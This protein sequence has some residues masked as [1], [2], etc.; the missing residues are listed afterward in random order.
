MKS[1]VFSFLNKLLQPWNLE[2]AVHRTTS[3]FSP[4]LLAVFQSQLREVQKQCPEFI[5]IEEFHDDRQDHPKRHIDLECEFASR[6]IAI[7]DPQTIL[8]I[9]SYR[10]WLIGVMA[11]HKVITID[12][13]KRE[14]YLRNEVCLNTDISNLSLEFGAIDMV[15][16][17]HSIEHIGLGRYGDR[18]D[19]EGDKRAI[20]KIIQALPPGGRF[21]FSVPVTLGKPCL[22]FNAHRIYHLDMVRHWSPRI[23]CQSEYFIKKHPARWIEES[24]VT[25]QLADFDIYCGSYQKL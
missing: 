9:G 14:S 8:D 12:V 15:V 6:E 11:H 1:A 25:S 22:A 2:I 17:L 24:E 21:I 20:E 23:Q 7:Y 5:V 13:R 10:H 16:S 18:F 4:D 3:S 19:P